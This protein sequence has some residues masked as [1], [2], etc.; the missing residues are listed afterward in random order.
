MLLWFKG[1][2]SMGGLPLLIRILAVGDIQ[3]MMIIERRLFIITQMIISG[4]AN[5]KTDR[6]PVRTQCGAPTEGPN[7][8]IVVLVLA[9]RKGQIDVNIRRIAL[10]SQC[11]QQ[12]LLRFR[13]LLLP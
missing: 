3:K 11:H 13:E 2:Q 7:R 8:E 1:D 6:R 10:Q 9:S 5:K 12:F 4:G